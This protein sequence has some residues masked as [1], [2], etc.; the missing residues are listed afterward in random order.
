MRLVYIDFPA[1]HSFIGSHSA[2]LSVHQRFGKA[3]LLQLSPEIR[4][5]I[6]GYIK[7]QEL[8]EI[9]AV[10]KKL[11]YIV[12]KRL[13]H[14]FASLREQLDSLLIDKFFE[15]MPKKESKHREHPL[16]DLYSLANIM[17]RRLDSLAFK[18]EDPIQDGYCCFY[19]G[20]M[21]DVMFPMFSWINSHLPSDNGS[22][23]IPPPEQFDAY[24]MAVPFTDLDYLLEHHF[25]KYTKADIKRRKTA[26][27]NKWKSHESAYRDDYQ[28]V[29]DSAPS[30]QSKEQSP[31]HSSEESD[32]SDGV[33]TA[34][35]ISEDDESTKSLITSAME[36]LSLFMESLSIEEKCRSLLILDLKE[37]DSEESDKKMI[38][39]ILKLIG[40]RKKPKLSPI[41]MRID[42]D[43]EDSVSKPTC[44]PVHILTDTEVDCKEVFAKY[45]QFKRAS[46]DI[47]DSPDFESS[48]TFESSSLIIRHCPIRF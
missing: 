38:R 23:V 3:M 1:I 16:N 34:E 5:K 32:S 28:V 26:A 48:R 40:I 37:E 4:S 19:A 36:N 24:Q 2:Q 44:R 15:A 17:K 18:F 43:M 31:S 14:A 33:F 25:I 12:E 27:L 6:F 29:E 22:A 41:V 7:Y 21:L 35:Q 8:C 46:K 9:R 10:C 11:Q 13:N 47:I 39:R 30:E 42:W 20:K 45:K